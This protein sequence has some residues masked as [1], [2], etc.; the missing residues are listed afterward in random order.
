MAFNELDTKLLWYNLT[1]TETSPPPPQKQKQK[2]TKKKKQQQ[3]QKTVLQT[4]AGNSFDQ[5]SRRAIIKYK[6]YHNLLI[7]FLIFTWPPALSEKF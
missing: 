7:Y 6:K 5:K 2:K 1:H 3:Q 4:I